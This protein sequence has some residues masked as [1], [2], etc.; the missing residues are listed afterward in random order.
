MRIATVAVETAAPE[1]RRT[2]RTLTYRPLGAFR[3]LLALM[4][5][6][7]HFEHLLRPPP[8]TYLREAGLG[9]VAVA[10]FFVISGFVVAEAS[11]VF[12]SGRPLAFFINR[13]L[14]VVPPY[15]AAL[16]LAVVVQASLFHAG[17]LHVWDFPT[18]VSPLEPRLIA[19][20]VLGLVPGFQT[21][22]L[23]GVDF[24][25]IPFVWTLRV[26]MAFYV[27]ALAALVLGNRF[28]KWPVIEMV[29]ALALLACGLFLLKGRPGLLS[30]G[31]MF[32]LGVS[33]CLLLHRFETRRLVFTATCLVL[34]G[35][36]FASYVQHGTPVLG[37]Q[38]AMI[39]ILLALL[40][41]LVLQPVCPWPKAWDRGLGELSYPLYLNHYIV[42]IF[43]YDTTTLRG[44][45][46][47][48]L[49]TVVSVGLAWMMA[50]AIER[51]LNGLRGHV[52]RAVL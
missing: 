37:L 31:P 39:S 21:R 10:V 41:W 49:G 13:L 25:F 43:L 52:R 28:R 23:A 27:T 33:L 2:M 3:F 42:G 36:G 8:P 44:P 12:Y 29:M 11:I 45:G 1:R 46:I 30:C 6:V 17:G 22:Y 50:R 19:A 34:T 24:E 18:A 35:L 32:L 48:A 14:R 9:M 5:V 38:V 51:P 40:A 7:R 47:F 20:G 16:A 15:L 4:V 26:E